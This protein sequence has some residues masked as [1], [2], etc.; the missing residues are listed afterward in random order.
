MKADVAVVGGGPAGL[1]AAI[2]ASRRG[3]SVVLFEQQ[4]PPIDKACGEGLMPDGL[5][6]L[7]RLGVELR[8]GLPFRGIRFVAGD[9]V[10]TGAFPGAPGLGLR[11]TALHAQLIAHAEHAGV[12]LRFG[13][14]VRQLSG[15]G[16]LTSEGECRAHSIVAAD[17]LRSRV[18]AWAGLPSRRGRARLG[19]RRHF[20]CAPWTDRVEVHWGSGAEA[21]VTPVGEN[22]VGVALLWSGPALS[23]DALL[24]RF[25]ALRTRLA[26]AP[27]CSRERGSGPF[28][29]RVVDVV[30]GNVALVGDASGYLDPLTGEGLAIS[31]HQAEALSVALAHDDLARYR[32]ADRRLR[33]LP[34]RVTALLLAVER[35]PRVRN[36]MVA[37]LA[38]DPPLFDR[39]LGV[40]TRQRSL[41]SLGL[42]SL[43]RLAACWVGPHRE[44][45]GTIGS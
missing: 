18:G 22:E 27:P 24:A 15:T 16:L 19:R 1:A 20:T 37:L 34:E 33:R 32:R 17:G 31:F 13:V 40:E 38:R 11:R 23:F 45:A 7:A 12:C 2:A 6:A 30:R 3:L 5:A 26:N 39:L 9:V 43:L 28:H 14:A 8:G 41:R 10:A 44:N 36:R 42:A 21:Y 25:P 35:R 4:R 29:Q